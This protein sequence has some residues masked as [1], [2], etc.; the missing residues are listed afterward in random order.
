MK[1]KAVEVYPV[2]ICNDCGSRHCEP[3][4]YVKKIGKILCG[5]GKVMNLTPIETFK[6]SPVFSP[7]HQAKAQTNKIKTERKDAFA[8][9]AFGTSKEKVKKPQEGETKMF[10][11]LNSKNTELVIQEAVDLLVS[12]GWKK[13]QAKEKVDVAS[14]QW[15]KETGKQLSSETFDDLANFLLFNQ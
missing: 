1:P 12:L 9:D 3:L 10:D 2:Y 7:P 11:F 8:P 14:K 6:V 4:D 5:C 15:V 13:K